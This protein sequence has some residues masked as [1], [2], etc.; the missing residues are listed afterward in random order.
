M[1]RTCIS[2]NDIRDKSLKEKLELIGRDLKEFAHL[3]EKQ[4]HL[5]AIYEQLMD[6]EVPM[7]ETDA[8]ADEAFWNATHRED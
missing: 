8:E 4:K 7:P 5:M 2:L 1:C 3:P 6:K